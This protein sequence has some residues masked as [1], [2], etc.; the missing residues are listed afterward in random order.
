MRDKITGRQFEVLQLLARYRTS[1]E[2]GATLGIS[3][4]A[5][6]Q[7]IRSAVAKLNASSRR[8]AASLFRE[9]ELKTEKERTDFGSE[10][11]VQPDPNAE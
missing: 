8:E 6:D 10:Y 3:A 1:K 9:W 5:V 7:R 11:L 2:I 4:Y